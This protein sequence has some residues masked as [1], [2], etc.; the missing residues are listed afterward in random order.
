ML[1]NADI[2]IYNKWYNRA[3]RLDEWKRVQIKGV[4]LYGGRAVTVTDHGLQTAN[5]YTVRIPAA[6]GPSGRAFVLPE[7]WAGTSSD[8]L[9]QFWTLQAGDIVVRG[10]VNDDITRAADVT[11]KY[12]ECFTMT[13]WRDNRR[14]S[15]AVQHWRVDGK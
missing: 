1:I 2:T 11:G 15:P 14:G 5:I 4:E 10:L 7:D 12:S 9:A 13:G 8:A 3:T 6:S